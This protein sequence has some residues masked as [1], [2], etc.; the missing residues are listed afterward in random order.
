MVGMAQHLLTRTMH[1]SRFYRATGFTV[2]QRRRAIGA[3]GPSLVVADPLKKSSNIPMNLLQKRL[4]SGVKIFAPTS[5]SR[6]RHN[7]AAKREDD[8]G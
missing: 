7:R 2:N 4:K 6:R 5:H 1:Y 8:R 3:P